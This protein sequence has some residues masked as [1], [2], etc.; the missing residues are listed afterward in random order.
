MAGGCGYIVAIYGSSLFSD[1]AADVDLIAAALPWADEDGLVSALE[2]I[3][4]VKVLE[5]GPARFLPVEVVWAGISID[6]HVQR[7]AGPFV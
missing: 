4:A 3:G 7:R 6:I 1:D 5:P 2:T